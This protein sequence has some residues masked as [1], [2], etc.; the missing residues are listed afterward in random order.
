MATKIPRSIRRTL[1]RNLKDDPDHDAKKSEAQ[2]SVLKSVKKDLR[3]QIET[4]DIKRTKIS[5]KVEPGDLVTIKTPRARTISKPGVNASKEEK[6]V[7]MGLV[8]YK[9][10]SLKYTGVEED[11]IIVMTPQHSSLKISPKS[12]EK[13]QE[14]PNIDKIRAN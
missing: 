13:V 4:G 7:I 9:E 3:D 10:S 12:I 6:R 5:W 8:L 11:Y 2:K 14:A 1:K